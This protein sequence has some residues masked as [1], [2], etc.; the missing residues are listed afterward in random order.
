MNDVLQALVY[1][2]GWFLFWSCQAVFGWIL[3]CYSKISLAISG[4]S[5]LLF[6][7]MLLTS[8]LGV[9][10]E[11]LNQVISFLMPYVLVLHGVIVVVVAIKIRKNARIRECGQD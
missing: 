6:L 3:R 9:V 5:A 4:S 1:P 10:P 2:V 7:I 11:K 8:P